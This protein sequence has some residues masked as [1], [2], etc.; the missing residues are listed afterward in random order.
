MGM[1]ILEFWCDEKRW[2]CTDVG[3]RVIAAICLE[4]HEV[5]P[6]EVDKNAPSSR[7]EQ[8]YVT[9]DPSWFAGSPYAVTEEVFDENPMKTCALFP[10]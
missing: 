6:V 3:T 8:N 2:R 4:P 7:Y 9:D 1:N 10:D 5:V